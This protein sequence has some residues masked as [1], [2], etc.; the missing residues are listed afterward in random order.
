MKNHLYKCLCEKNVFLFWCPNK[1]TVYTTFIGDTVLLI[2][3][4]YLKRLI[5][6]ASYFILPLM[7]SG[8]QVAWGMVCKKFRLVQCCNICTKDYLILHLTRTK[9]HLK[10]SFQLWLPEVF[11]KAQFCFKNAPFTVGYEICHTN[12]C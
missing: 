8:N 12:L 4:S 11:L 5:P 9:N 10:K 3:A 2:G 7:F 1:K 6:G